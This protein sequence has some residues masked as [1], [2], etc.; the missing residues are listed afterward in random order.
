MC[1]CVGGGEGGG[2]GGRIPP[3][4]TIL[5]ERTSV[6]D[7]SHHSA[8]FTRLQSYVTHNIYRRQVNVYTGVVHT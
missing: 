2:V 1:V 8:P 6:V 3:T 4:G 7:T 5:M